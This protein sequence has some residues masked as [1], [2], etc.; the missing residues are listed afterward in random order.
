MHL[1]DGA[2]PGPGNIFVGGDPVAGTPATQITPEILTAFEF[3]L[4][5][6]VTRAGLALSKP[7][8]T[9]LY[10]AISLLAARRNSLRNWIVNGGPSVDQRNSGLISGAAAYT[11][12]R[13]LFFPGGTGTGRYRSPTTNPTW[14]LTAEAEQTRWRTYAKWEQ[15]VAS[16]GA[17]P[18]IAQR[19]EGVGQLSGT[20]VTLSFFAKL[21]SLSSG[22]TVTLTPSFIQNFGPGGSA[23]V[24]TTGSSIVLT[25][26]N[27]LARFTATV[28]L[29]SIAAGT[30]ASVMPP[31]DYLE[32]RLT[33]PNG[34]TFEIRT[35]GVQFEIGSAATEFEVRPVELELAMCRRYFET[36]VSSSGGI[37]GFFGS[38]SGA[39]P[40][41]AYNSWD[42]GTV[43]L[44]AQQHFA[45]I[46]RTIPT[47]IWYSPATGAAGN[48]VWEGADRSVIQTNNTSAS[49]TGS[50]QVASS[51]L[52]SEV[53][54]AWTADA[55]I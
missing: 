45:Q 27:A 19:I 8:N 36:S 33:G 35:V 18:Y 37:Y 29:P 9:Q 24:T 40:D 51:R 39:S 10:Q 12:D 20:V 25:N 21:V 53:R 34:V 22:T 50:P 47:V 26:G 55:E 43:A 5:N 4:A 15:T 54:A 46:K 7:D 30:I 3:E 16:S 48:I 31:G 28:T 41:A 13:W 52:A 49:V 38:I 1:V 14:L 44:T 23:P 6:V 11:M 32:V 2:N 42:S 17:Q